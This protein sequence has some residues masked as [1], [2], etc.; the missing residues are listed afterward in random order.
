MKLSELSKYRRVY[1]A[2]PYSK[3]PKG[4]VAAFEEISQIGGKLLNAGVHF[5]G[6]ISHSHPVSLY[7]NIPL[8]DYSIWLPFDEHYMDDCEAI[9][10]AMMD[11]WNTS[12]GV[13]HEIKYFQS[14]GKPVYFLELETMEVHTRWIS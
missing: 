3:Y 8:A 11:T 5:Y 10:V 13:N 14:Q 2:S 12:Y 9:V 4:T 7:G 1:L 6:P